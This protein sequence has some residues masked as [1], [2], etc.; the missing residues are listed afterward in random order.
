MVTIKVTDQGTGI[1]MDDLPHV[2]EPFFSRRPDGTALGL[3]VSHGIVL[4]HGGSIDV[5]SIEGKGTVVT[6]NL[7]QK[8]AEVA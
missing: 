2:F 4:A 1:P 7:P 8:R 6:V 5:Q 3:A